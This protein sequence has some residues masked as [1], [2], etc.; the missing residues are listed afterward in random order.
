MDLLKLQHIIKAV[1]DFDETE[2]TS[3]TMV[4]MLLLT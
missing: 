1:Y 4:N 3:S 2:N